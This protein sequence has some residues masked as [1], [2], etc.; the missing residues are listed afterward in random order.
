MTE[1]EEVTPSVTE[2][3]RAAARQYAAQTAKDTG[4][5]LA[6]AARMMLD[7]PQLVA[8]ELGVTTA[9]LEALVPEITDIDSR[10]C[11]S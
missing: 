11:S 9:Q 5:D 4:V 6:I 8:A 10:R 7:E 2:E 1:K 3:K